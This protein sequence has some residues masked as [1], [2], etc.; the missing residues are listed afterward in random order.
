MSLK[1][2]A[3]LPS[4]LQISIYKMNKEEIPRALSNADI[5]VLVLTPDAERS[6]WVPKEIGTAMGMRKKVIRQETRRHHVG[7]MYA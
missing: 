6:E 3:T 1:N 7:T 4:T 2:L 5:I